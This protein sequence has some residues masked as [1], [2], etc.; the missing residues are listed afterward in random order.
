MIDDSIGVNTDAS[1]S[2]SLDHVTKLFA[3]ATTALELVGSGLIVEPPG[4]ELTLLRPL[5]REGRLA[6]RED[7]DAHPALFS[8]ILALFFNVSVRPAEHLDDGT[9]LATLVGIRLVDGGTLPDEVNCFRIDGERLTSVIGTDLKAERS[10]AKG[11]IDLVLVAVLDAFTIPVELQV[12][13]AGVLTTSSG[14]GS[15]S[16]TRVILD[17]V[18]AH[19][20]AK[21]LVGILVRLRAGKV[22]L[23]RA[24]GP[25][26]WLRGLST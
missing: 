20:T 11:T 3:G 9:L 18:V 2:A 23:E 5:I 25:F 22:C 13:N 12:L 14:H 1:G 10:I 8:Q 7:L 17:M 15:G 4:V 21:A 24:V 19:N 6:D 26:G 16:F